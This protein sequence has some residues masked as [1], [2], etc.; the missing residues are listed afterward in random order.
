MIEPRRAPT[1]RER[2]ARTKDIVN[3]DGKNGQMERRAAL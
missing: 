2:G 3:R 1:D